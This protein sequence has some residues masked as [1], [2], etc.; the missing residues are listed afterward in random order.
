MAV[1]EWSGILDSWLLVICT[2]EILIFY[3]TACALGKCGFIHVRK[4][5]SQIS[6]DFR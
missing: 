3:W 2:S 5:S 1:L 6:L 4:G